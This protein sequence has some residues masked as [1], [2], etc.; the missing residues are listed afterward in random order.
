MSQRFAVL[1][2]VGVS[3]LIPLTEV[4]SVESVLDLDR[5]RKS[6]GSVGSVR[7]SGEWFPVFSLTDDLEI[8]GTLPETFRVCA[9]VGI[10]NIALALA[11]RSLVALDN[12]TIHHHPLPEC[13]RTP[14]SPVRA[15]A[16]DG[17]RIL[18]ETSVND[19]VPI[20]EAA[21]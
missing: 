12:S 19:L 2:L 14:R 16:Y 6:K 11:G 8:T 1:Q 4:Y 9:I 17:Q 3:L 7:S 21:A 5:H 10:G 20:I 15:L 18:C 13:M